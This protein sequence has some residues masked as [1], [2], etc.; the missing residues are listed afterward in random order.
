[1]RLLERAAERLGRQLSC[2]EIL[3]R[4]VLAREAQDRDP[5]GLDGQGAFPI[6]EEY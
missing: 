3:D 2:W 4:I 6:L 1:M 5:S